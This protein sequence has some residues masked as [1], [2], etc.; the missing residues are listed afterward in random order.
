[1][2]I[3][4][5]ISHFNDYIH[6]YRLHKHN[7]VYNYYCSTICKF[8]ITSNDIILSKFGLEFIKKI[9]KQFRGVDSNYSKFVNNNFNI[10]YD[11]QTILELYGNVKEIEYIYITKIPNIKYEFN[12]SIELKY[13]E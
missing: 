6:L 12:K 8:V 4:L 5:L 9:I 10:S 3:T 11:L 7:I 13:I 1:M 2:N